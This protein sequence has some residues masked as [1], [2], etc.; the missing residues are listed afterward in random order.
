VRARQE[1]A[2]VGRAGPFG[3]SRDAA[4]A[5][6][7]LV[8]EWRGSCLRLSD[9]RAAA[10]VAPGAPRPGSAVIHPRSEWPDDQRR[11]L[12]GRPPAAPMTASVRRGRPPPGIGRRLLGRT[13]TQSARANGTGRWATG[14]L[15]GHLGSARRGDRCGRYSPSGLGDGWT[16]RSRPAPALSMSELDRTAAWADA[17]CAEE[18]GHPLCLGLLWSQD[19]DVCLEFERWR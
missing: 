10:L 11:R 19:S 15:P 9:W 8:G 4:R 12:R 3:C 17:G 14:A 16:S 13:P 18:F 1:G 7:A 2:R 5:Q 6:R